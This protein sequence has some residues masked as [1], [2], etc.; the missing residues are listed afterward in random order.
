MVFGLCKCVFSL[1]R[2]YKHSE[3]RDSPAACLHKQTVGSGS[4]GGVGFR[5]TCFAGLASY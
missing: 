4:S 1:V 5:L 3:N 2:C